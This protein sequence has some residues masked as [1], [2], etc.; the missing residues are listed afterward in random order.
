[1]RAPTHRYTWEQY[2]TLS[3]ES[4]FKLEFFA[5][6]IYAMAGGTPAHAALGLNMG[7]ELRVRLKGT[8][9][10]AYSSDLRIRVEETGLGTYPDVSVVCG[11]LRY[12][13]SDPRNTVVNPT[14]VVE[15][16]SDST[17]DYDRGVKFEH[18]QRIPT[19]R[20]FVLVSHRERRVQVFRRG[21]P[22]AEWRQSEVTAG[23]RVRLESIAVEIPIDAIYDGVALT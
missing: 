22:D 20:E 2:L 4:S 3:G 1:M 18:Y 17:E 5:G 13:P 14:V 21:L 6:E 11:E 19:L 23:E 10:R 7:A 16:L 12:D 8:P 9:C 15:V